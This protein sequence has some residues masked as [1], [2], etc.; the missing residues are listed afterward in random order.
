MKAKLYNQTYHCIYYCLWWYFYNLA[1]R[2]PIK[3]NLLLLHSRTF[4]CTQS[5]N[6][7]HTYSGVHNLVSGQVDQTRSAQVDEAEIN[8]KLWPSQEAKALTFFMPK[9][10]A[11]AKD[12]KAETNGKLWKADALTFWKM[13]SSKIGCIY[14]SWCNMDA[15]DIHYIND[16][17]ILRNKS[18][19]LRTPLIS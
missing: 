3:S 17:L 16:T 6:S 10:E 12:H 15:I 4:E 14:M 2:Q 18:L 19:F 8:P 5:F 11:E 7:H 13:Q 9:F 1:G